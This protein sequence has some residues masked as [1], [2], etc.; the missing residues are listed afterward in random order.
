MKIRQTNTAIYL[1][2]IAILSLS[3]ILLVWIRH[4]F[5]QEMQSTV[6]SV[7]SHFSM[8]TLIK[9]PDDIQIN[10]GR[11]TETVANNK[12]NP[13]I[14]ELFVSKI[15]RDKGEHL[16]HPYYYE[17]LYPDWKTRL[18]S[19]GWICEQLI[20]NKAPYGCLYIN[21]DN[22]ALRNV[23][24]VAI[25][26]GLLILISLII[27]IIK[28]KAQERVIS[29]TTIELKEKEDELIHLEKLALAGRLTA[30]IFHD[31]KK[32][33]FNIKHEIAAADEELQPGDKLKEL[34]KRIKTQID[35]FISMLREINIEKFVRASAVEESEYADINELLERSIN[36]VKYEQGNVVVERKFDNSI[37][38]IL[39]HPYRLIQVFSNII[40]NAY[41]AM[42]GEGKIIL[43]TGSESGRVVIEIEDSGPGASDVDIEKMFDPFFTTKAQ[44]E[45]SGLGL[46]ISR[47]IVK[48]AGGSL[49]ALRADPSKTG[50]IFRITL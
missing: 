39:I 3:F 7:K 34:F 41:E 43:R 45:G 46:Y 10:F 5:K 47:N 20:S 8:E 11:I 42:G 33:V 49:E 18:K 4:N 17:A 31:I 16:V 29:K 27:F 22:S 35:L 30:N 25:V 36:L 13:F 44:K 50:M 19:E 21:L 15:I 37:K 32:P 40:L 28:M 23:T 38:P 2:N 14:K 9:T 12:R 24:L 1:A 48:Q 26:I 6:S